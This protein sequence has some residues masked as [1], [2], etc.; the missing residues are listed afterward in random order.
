V[1]TRGED[2]VVRV[3]APGVDPDKDLEVTLEDGT[4]WVRNERRFDDEDKVGRNRRTEMPTGAF[5]RAV[6]VPQAL[7]PEDVKATYENGVVTVTLSGATGRPEALRIPI[8]VGVAEQAPK[9]A[10][11]AAA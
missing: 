10:G 9:P 4:L 5:E 1:V 6:R 3:E 11:Q 2:L 7:K 8:E